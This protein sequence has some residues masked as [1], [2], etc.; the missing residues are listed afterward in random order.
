MAHIELNVLA[1]FTAKPGMEQ[2]V[3]EALERMIEPS[4]NEEANVGYALHQGIKD[5]SVFLLYEGWKSQ[6]GLQHHMNQPYFKRMDDDLRDTLERPYEVTLIH[7]IAGAVP[8]E[9]E[10]ISAG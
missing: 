2:R 3:R 5:A 1:R 4:L 9:A 7:K 8:I 6:E 10:H